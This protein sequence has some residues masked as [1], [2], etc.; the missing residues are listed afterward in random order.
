MKIWKIDLFRHGEIVAVRSGIIV[1]PTQDEAAK[2]A[3]LALGEAY[4]DY[5]NVDVSEIED[6]TSLP[7]GSLYLRHT[8]A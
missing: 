5:A 7:A 8:H 1:A 4:A 2:L 6:I 3:A